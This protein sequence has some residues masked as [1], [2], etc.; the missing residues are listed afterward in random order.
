M[1]AERRSWSKKVALADID[2]SMMIG[3]SAHV[4]VDRLYAYFV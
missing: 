2:M 4:D 3:S 1:A